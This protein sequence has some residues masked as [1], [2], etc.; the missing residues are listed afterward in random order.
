MMDIMDIIGFEK[1]KNLF[2]N[3]QGKMQVIL[4]KINFYYSLLFA[5]FG[6]FLSKAK[7][8]DHGSY[9]AA[10]L[11]EMNPSTLRSQ[12]DKLDFECGRRNKQ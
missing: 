11:L 8:R 4:K 10:E 2:F 3:C 6:W 9:G 7:G 1:Y 12:M 5:T